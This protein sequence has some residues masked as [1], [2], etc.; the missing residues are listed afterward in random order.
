MKQVEVSIIAGWTG[1]V[2][3][4]HSFNT[5]FTEALPTAGGLVGLPKNQQANGTLRLNSF[6]WL[7]YKHTLNTSHFEKGTPKFLFIT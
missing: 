6:G 1:L 5:L 7:F 3:S 4:L 2:V